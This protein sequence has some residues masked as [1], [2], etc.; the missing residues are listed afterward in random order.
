VGVL[1]AAGCVYIMMGLP[2]QAWIRFGGWLV[3]GLILYILYGFKHSV[4]RGGASNATEKSGIA[5]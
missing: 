2:D 1:S 4:L 3:I 5:R